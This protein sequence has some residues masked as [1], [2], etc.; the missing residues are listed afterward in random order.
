MTKDILFRDVIF[1]AI[2]SIVKGR[3]AELHLISGDVL[4]LGEL[5]TVGSDYL[6]IYNGPITTI[7]PFSAIRKVT[8][9][10]APRVTYDMDQESERARQER[11]NA[12]EDV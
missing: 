7:V 1:D 12:G 4:V 9:A 8:T 5:T 3:R 11:H 2:G 10:P 6:S